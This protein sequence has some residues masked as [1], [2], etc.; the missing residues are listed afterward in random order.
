MILPQ[1]HSHASCIACELHQEAKNPGVPTVH[2]E[3]SVFPSPAKPFLIVVGMNPGYNE[4]KENRPFV[5]PTGNMLKNVYLKVLN[6]LDTHVVYFTNAARCVTHSNGV[7]LKNS[8]LKACWPHTSHDIHKILEWHTVG[9]SLLCLGTHAVQSVTR[10]MMDKALTLSKAIE[11]QGKPIKEGLNF[12]ATYH[13][14][15]V[16]RQQRLKYAVSEHLELIGQHLHGAVP[17]P[18]LPT[19]IQPRSPQ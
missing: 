1:L 8:H 5:G 13:P 15:G 9:G 2:Y 14:A 16:M 10:H 19:I 6:I 11:N 7:A 4:D 3:Q 17:S 12:F 18:S